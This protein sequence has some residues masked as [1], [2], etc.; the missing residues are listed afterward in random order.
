MKVLVYEDNLMWSSRLTNSLSKLGYEPILASEVSNEAPIA[1]VN[2]GTFGLQWLVPS[3]RA[4]GVVTLGHAGHK[5]KEL[6]SLGAEVGCDILATNSE[7]TFKIE[8][9]LQRAQA[10]VSA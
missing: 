9:L 2:L 3:L 1:I 7:L 8:S 4:L 10:M 6:H 5:E